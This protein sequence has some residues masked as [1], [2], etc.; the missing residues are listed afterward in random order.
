M[1]STMKVDAVG[2]GAIATALAY[3]AASG[4]IDVAKLT[5]AQRDFWLKQ[6]L[7]TKDNAAAILAAKP[8]LA[9]YTYEKIKA[10][11]WATSP[12]QIPVGANK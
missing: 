11:F 3:A 6:T 9:E 2:Q 4:D 7:V 10:N 8:D 12:G 5:Q 1:L